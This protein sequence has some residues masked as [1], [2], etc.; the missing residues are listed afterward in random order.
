MR[1]ISSRESCRTWSELQE[2][3]DMARWTVGSSS[4]WSA[5]EKL[6]GGFIANVRSAGLAHKL[7]ARSQSR[8]R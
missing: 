4:A 7:P 5:P 6:P 2:R 1:K 8:S 3:R